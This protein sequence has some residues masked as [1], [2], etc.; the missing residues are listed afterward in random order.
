M[1][2]FLEY[3]PVKSLLPPGF[4]SRTADLQYSKGKFPISVARGMY[5]DR[6][7]VI[8]DA[9]GLVRP[10]KGKGINA[11][12]LSGVRAAEALM[13][14]GISKEA[15]HVFYQMNS[16]ITEDLLY[17]KILRQLVI[18]GANYSLLDAVIKLS[19]QDRRLSE[20]LFNCV[21]AHKNFKTIWE[22]TRDWRL[23]T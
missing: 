22:E 7:V 9:A 21:S 6:Y 1:D 10:F 3:P 18:F 2:V 16:E 8:G 17:G 19:Q 4:D 20:A 14:V 15:L 23:L 11:R 12:C 13:N 5:G